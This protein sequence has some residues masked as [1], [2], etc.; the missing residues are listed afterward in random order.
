MVNQSS[1]S[2]IVHPEDYVFLLIQLL[3][4]SLYNG[5][6]QDTFIISF[7]CALESLSFAVFAG[8]SKQVRSNQGRPRYYPDLLLFLNINS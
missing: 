1:V 5:A 2:L 8:Y 6:E 7:G 4:R 3:V